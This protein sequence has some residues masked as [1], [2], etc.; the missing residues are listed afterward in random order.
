M[1]DQQGM[2]DHLATHFTDPVHWKPFG[3]DWP[4]CNKGFESKAN[5]QR[6]Q[7][8]HTKERPYA[9]LTCGKRFNQKANLSTH[10]KRV[11]AREMLADGLDCSILENSQGQS[12]VEAR[13]NLPFQQ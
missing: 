7:L 10:F 4:K 5:L 6:H 2:K 13:N 11:H 9:C 1:Q 12:A 8:I 3:C